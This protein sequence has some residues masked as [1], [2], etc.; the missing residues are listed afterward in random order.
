M[1]PQT[2]VPGQVLQPWELGEGE[3]TVARVRI[4]GDQAPSAVHH[5][6]ADAV[7]ERHDDGS[8]VLE[9]EVTNTDAFRSFVITFLEHAEVLSPPQLRDDLV[10]WLSALAGGP[11]R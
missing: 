11:A 2:A 7:R 1:R 8:V 3:P 5:V 4:D 10:A 9:L 6:G